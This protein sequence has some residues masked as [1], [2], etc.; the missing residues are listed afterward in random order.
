MTR[1]RDE[2]LWLLFVAAVASPFVAP[3]IGAMA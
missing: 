1:L 2:P 3:L